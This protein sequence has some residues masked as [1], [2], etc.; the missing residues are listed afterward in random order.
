M[1]NYL[2]GADMGLEIEREIK[3][4]NIN[5][6]IFFDVVYFSVLFWK[7][8]IFK[9]ILYIKVPILY[10]QIRTMDKITILNF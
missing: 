8:K 2:T 1:G 3:V 9:I 7:M 5:Y 4:S 6:R 10:Y